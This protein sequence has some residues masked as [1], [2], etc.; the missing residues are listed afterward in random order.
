MFIADGSCDSSN[1][2]FSCIKQ[3][4]QLFI[5]SALIEAN[6]KYIKNMDGIRVCKSKEPQLYN[7]F[8]RLSVGALNKRLPEYV[9]N[10]SEFQSRILMESLLEGDGHT[11]EYQ[12]QKSFSRYGTISKYL[13]DDITRLAL[14]CSWSG[15]VK[16][17]EIPNGVER[18]GTRTMGS[19]IGTTVNVTQKH[20]YYKVSII[21]K[22]N[23][24][25]INKKVNES[26]EEKTIDYS[27]KV[28]CIEVPSSHT[29]YMRESQTSP[30]LIIGNSSRHG[31]QSTHIYLLLLLYV[32]VSLYKSRKH[33]NHLFIILFNYL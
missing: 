4:K 24:P 19:R 25:W 2:S 18:T 9:W 29:Y 26:N 21:R 31:K 12:D 5:E 30:C 11:Y 8:N 13:A 6:I 7:E 32:L 3:R 14:H 20:V 1:I 17:A 16:I 22:Q 23:Q 15:I 33:S 10:L 28:Y 27:G